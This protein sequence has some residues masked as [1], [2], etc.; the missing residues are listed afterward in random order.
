MQAMEKQGHEI[1]ADA[2]TFMKIEKSPSG[3]L[4]KLQLENT[5]KSTFPSKRVPLIA[6]NF[7]PSYGWNHLNLKQ[8]LSRYK[9]PT[10]SNLEKASILHELMRRFFCL[11]SPLATLLIGIYWSLS[12]DRKSRQKKLPILL[13]IFLIASYFFA[14]HSPHIKSLSLEP[15]VPL[16]NVQNIQYNLIYCTLLSAL[17]FLVPLGACIATCYY[18][19]NKTNT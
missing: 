3:T 2:T 6:K 4:E 1:K 5:K 18:K 9:T 10:S 19:I 7:A 14:L 8:L 15:S 13:I 11:I 17:L 16:Q 12:I